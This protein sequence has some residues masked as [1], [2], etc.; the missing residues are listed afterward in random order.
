MKTQEIYQTVTDKIVAMIEAKQVLPWQKGWNET[1]LGSLQ[2]NYISGRAYRGINQFI[3]LGAGYASPFWM[4]FKQAKAKGGCV[5]KGEKAQTV[6]FWKVYRKDTG[7]KNAKGEKVMQPIFVLKQYCVF[8]AEQIDGIEFPAAAPQ[9]EAQEIEACDELEL[10]LANMPTP[11]KGLNFGGDRAFYRP[12]TDTIQLPRP[13]QFA[14][15]AHYYGTKAHEFIHATGHASRL[16]REGITE[17]NGF[18]S[19]TYSKEELVAELGA[20]FML[21]IFG[22]QTPE[23]EANN[24]AYIK[25][26]LRELKNDPAMIFKASSHAQKAVD[27]IL[28]TTFESEEE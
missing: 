4:T 15:R 13:E 18:G 26:W 12:L 24:A 8:N 17:Y 27:Y 21:S 1:A 22:L 6:Y 11:I 23:N 14:S 2:K 9:T 19:E 3:L 20:S 7:E 16:N 10:A 5:R 25:G 28:G